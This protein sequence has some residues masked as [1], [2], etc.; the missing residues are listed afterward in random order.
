MHTIDINVF[1]SSKWIET[2]SVLRETKTEKN[3]K[4]RKKEG[5][6]KQNEM[7]MFCFQVA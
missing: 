7:K 1:S 4:R 2:A 6:T 3:S 5:K